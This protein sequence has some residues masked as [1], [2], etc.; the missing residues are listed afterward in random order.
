MMTARLALQLNAVVGLVTSAV[1]GATI[2]L[3]LTRPTEVAVA[4]A[5]H[6]YGAMI[7]AVGQELG[8]WL[9]ALLWYV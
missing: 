7:A 1:A 3:L 4:V 2:W 6:E 5:N 8:S 9:Q